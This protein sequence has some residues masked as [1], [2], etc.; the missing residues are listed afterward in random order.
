MNETAIKLQM[1]NTRYC[2]LDGVEDPNNVTTA[3]DIGLLM[4][5]LIEYDLFRKIIT[6]KTFKCQA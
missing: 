5:K 6:T 1:S 3:Y 2:N 4:S